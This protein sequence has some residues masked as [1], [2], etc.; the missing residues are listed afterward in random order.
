MDYNADSN[1]RKFKKLIEDALGTDVELTGSV[2][3]GTNDTLSDFDY[4][5]RQK[6]SN[7]EQNLKS[8]KRKFRAEVVYRNWHTSY[9]FIFVDYTVLSN[10]NVNR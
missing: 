6:F 4:G 2:A 1:A 9:H 8:L 5:I 10:H 3:A 7:V